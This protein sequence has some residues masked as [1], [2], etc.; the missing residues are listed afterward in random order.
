MLQAGCVPVRRNAQS[1]QWQ[2]LLVQSRWTPQVWLFPKGT[3][4]SNETA[5]QAAVRE[6]RE[7]GGVIGEL[8]PKLGSWNINRG[9]KQKQKM[10]LLYVTT[11]FSA[12][13][14]QWKERK[15][16]ARAWHSLEDAKCILTSLPPDQQRTEL[17]EMLLKTEAL[18]AQ[19]DLGLQLKDASESDDDEQV[20]T[21][22][23]AQ[24]SN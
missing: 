19:H 10:W 15:K 17:M 18:L 6:T 1:S 11:Q 13:N 8:G 14:K 4:E 12:D 21:S 2:V 20:E 3:V 7:E 5:K 16:R 23:S 22:A 24:T 9:S